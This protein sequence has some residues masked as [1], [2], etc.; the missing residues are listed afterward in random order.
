MKKRAREGDV[1][2]D[3]PLPPLLSQLIPAVTQK[4]TVAGNFAAAKETTTNLSVADGIIWFPFRGAGNSIIRCILAAANTVIGPFICTPSLVSLAL[5]PTPI[6]LTMT[7][8][9]DLMVP[10]S[11]SV[12]NSQVRMSPDLSQVYCTGRLIGGSITINSSTGGDSHQ[13]VISGDIGAAWVSDTRD[14]YDFNRVTSA[15]RSL[16]SRNGVAGLKISTG[17]RMTFPGLAPAYAPVLRD[18]SHYRGQ[19]VMPQTSG[20]ISI[21]NCF[22]LSHLGYD[23]SGAAANVPLPDLP[24]GAIPTVTVTVPAQL[25]FTAAVVPLRAVHIFATYDGTGTKPISYM[26]SHTILVGPNDNGQCDVTP[27]AGLDP[28]NGLWLG[29]FIL[30][31]CPA[32]ANVKF[33]A[34]LSHDMEQGLSNCFV[35][36]ID[37]SSAGVIVTL[38]GSLFVQTVATGQN[39]Q[40]TPVASIPD[41]ASLDE[42]V[43][44]I[45][46]FLSESGE[47]CA[48]TPLY[49]AYFTV[50]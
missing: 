25:A 7:L 20:T 39:S 32:L 6:V 24:W 48:V 49:S 23:G 38:S 26:T 8:N 5:H 22:F 43:A 40:F 15:A 31:D 37:D 27:T 46:S 11:Q 35:S 28:V 1:G 18:V 36:R 17:L 30:I 14:L 9:R 13:Q 50:S 19:L 10:V 2:R 42:E 16:F 44:A 12:S 29:V 3:R 41:T 34:W 45:R 33:S 47:S 4:I 21:N